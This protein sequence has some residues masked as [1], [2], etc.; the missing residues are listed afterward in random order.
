MTKPDRQKL[1]ILMVLLGVL[2]VTGVFVYRMN[3]PQTTAAVQVSETKSPTNPAAAPADAARIRLDLLEKSDADAG[4][5]KRNLFQYQQAP[6]P[7]PPAPPRGGPAATLN[8]AAAPP[9]A[10]TLPVARPAGPP[11]P[12]PITL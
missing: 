7:L 4:I 6:P 9:P 2:G 11:P 3:E 12:P 8:S 1:S 10:V 5:A